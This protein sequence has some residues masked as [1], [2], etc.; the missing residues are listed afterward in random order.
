M[1]KSIKNIIKN[2]KNYCYGSDY[3][4][5][6]GLVVVPIANDIGLI[7]GSHVISLLTSTGLYV[8]TKGV[9]LSAY[10]AVGIV[11]AIWKC[12]F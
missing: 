7:L 4:L 11:G 12:F 2:I 3:I 5:A 9:K 10:T 6:T 8:A 1:F